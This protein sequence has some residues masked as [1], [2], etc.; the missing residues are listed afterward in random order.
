MNA[1]GMSTN[2]V[3]RLKAEGFQ[4]NTMDDRTNLTHSTRVP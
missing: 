4:E 2:Q 1:E 3:D